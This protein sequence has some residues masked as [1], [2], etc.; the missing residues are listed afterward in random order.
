M[1]IEIHGMF[2]QNSRMD[3]QKSTVCHIAHTQRGTYAARPR[4]MFSR[5][6]TAKKMRRG[7]FSFRPFLLPF[8]QK[9]TRMKLSSLLLCAALLTGAAPLPAGATDGHVCFATN[10]ATGAIASLSLAGDTTNMNWMLRTDGSQYAWVTP[11]YGWG[12]G[13]FS[14]DGCTFS[15]QT[16][17]AL[18]DGGR[19]VEYVAGGV[20]I[21]VERSEAE[22]GFAERFTFVNEGAAPVRLTDMGIYTPFNDNYPDARTC[23]TQRCH[24]HVWTGGS[25]A[26]VRAVRMSGR[27]DGL[28]LALTEGRVWDYDVWE[29]GQD[30]GSS[31][32]RGVIALCPQDKVLAPGESTRVGWTVFRYD[33]EV[34]FNER[35]MALGGAIVTS[36]KYVYEVGEVAEVTAM[37]KGDVQTK[38]VKIENPGPMDVPFEYAPGKVTFA[39]LLGVSSYEGLIQ[40][41][42][43]F[44]ISHQQMNDTADAR[45]GAY[46]VYDNETQKIYLNDDSRASSD[47]D[48]GRERV[49]MGVLIAQWQALHPSDRQLQSLRRYA[50]FLRTE[51]QRADYTTFSRVGHGGKNRGYNY[52]W[53]AD[54]YFR[55]YNLTGDKQ[56]AR[57]GYGTMRA[58]FRHFGYGFYAID[59]PVT[60][61]LKTLADAGMAAERDTL[62]ADYKATADAFAKNRL[63]FPRHEVNY[64]QSIVAPAIL[65]LEQLYK[66]TDAKPVGYGAMLLEGMV[67]VVSIVCVMILSRNDEMVTKAPNFIYASGIGSFM[68]LIGIPASFGISFGLTSIFELLKDNQTLTNTLPIDIYIIP[69]NTEIESLKLA[70]NLRD[71]N[72]KVDFDM[73][74]KKMKKSLDYCNKENIPYVIILGEDEI[75]NNSFKLKDMNNKTEYLIKF[76]EL[77]KIKEIIKK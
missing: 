69:M 68:E 10:P 55:M 27:G 59:I 16:P 67:A 39:R 51:L 24:A 76:T 56:Y 11:K 14:I 38:T 15:W 70:N 58:F 8:G 77:N 26:Y 50:A 54:L 72:Y 30:K 61:S 32:N 43:D 22:G 4:P 25:T 44:I 21:E 17:T 64:E 57:D 6:G 5:R 46:M 62:L 42:V 66:E 36:P 63:D 31:N 9:P 40:K 18:A 53:I 7:V 33:S 49:G 47:T 60:L 34:E 71:L 19:R 73:T 48:E 3:A 20:R 41:R 2:R 23:M 65:F 74:S 35:V 12:L 45:C 28:G 75:K 1:E 13:Y 52:P 37:T 29:R